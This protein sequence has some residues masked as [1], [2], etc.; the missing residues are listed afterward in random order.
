MEPDISSSSALASHIALLNESGRR[1][2]GPLLLAVHGDVK[3][4]GESQGVTRESNWHHHPRGQFMCIESG[5]AYL[6]TRQG[7]WLLPPRR[8]GWVPPGELHAAG[9]AGVTVSW[10]L[11]LTPA[12]SRGLP[13]TPCV[14]GVTDLAH[15]LIRR[16]S[17][18]TSRERLDPPQRRIV[19]TLLDELRRARRDEMSLPLPSD[20]RLL[21]VAN[22]IIEN[23]STTR[24]MEEWAD[25]AGMSPRSMNRLFQAQVGMN[26]ASWRQQAMLVHALERLSQGDS[27]ATVADAL[28]YATPSSFIAMFRRFFGDSPSHFLRANLESPGLRAGMPSP[29]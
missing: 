21:R 17:S 9:V 20:R 3:T 13:D 27:V 26:F 18:W 6:R 4:A 15:A 10:N 1:L 7:S 29:A 5:L 2:Q 12:A 14:M 11:F 8:V 25:W 19:M 16:A 23:P 28:G 24:R 22:A